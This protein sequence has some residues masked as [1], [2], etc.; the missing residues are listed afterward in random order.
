MRVTIQSIEEI[1]K[2]MDG[3]AQAIKIISTIAANTNLLSM[4]AAIEAAHAGEAGRGFAVVAGEIRKLSENTRENSVNISRTLKSI[5]DGIAVTS[6]Q[7]GDTGG[8]INTMA[9]EISSFAATISGI[10]NT[11][12]E[13]S[14]GSG[15]ITAALDSLNSQ[16]GTVKTDY[17]E[18]LSMTE[19]L[20][21]A[22]LDLNMLSKKKVLVVDDEE[23]V[24]IMTK[25]MLKKDYNVTTVNSG[26]AALDLFMKGY[27]PHLILLD[28]NMPEIDGWDT[29]IRVR[30][31]SKLHQAQ[32]AIYSVSEDPEDMTK[33]KKLGAVEYIHK[34]AKKDELLEKVEKLMK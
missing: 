6:K 3:I 31:F 9:K 10:I 28:L 7:S 12:G 8:R 20:R 24:L 11:F 2:S 4:N 21:A 22:M 14:A 15:E 34:P 32:I 25:E 23:T 19:K 1:S 5:I 30:N 18:I 17:E 27:A 16:S 26:K 33:A 29:L 13:M